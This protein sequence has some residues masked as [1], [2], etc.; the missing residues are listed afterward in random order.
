MAHLASCDW[1]S[2]CFLGVDSRGK[3]QWCF[4]DGL[5]S[6]GV[7]KQLAALVTEVTAAVRSVD[8][9][10]L[11]MREAG[12]LGQYDEMMHARRALHEQRVECLQPF[13]RVQRV[14]FSRGRTTVAGSAPAWSASAAATALRSSHHAV[15]DGFLGATAA[16]ALGAHVRGM[17]TAGELAPGEVAAGLQQATRG[18]LM[19]WLT[20]GGGA[21]AGGSGVAPSLRTLLGALDELVLSLQRCIPELARL[22]LLR[23]EVQATCYPG[24]GAR[25]TRHVDDASR[26]GRVLTCILYLNEAWH[27]GAGGELRLHLSPAATGAA[28]AK[29]VDV[30]PISD[31]L[32]VFWSDARCPHEVLPS[33]EDRYAVSI[34]YTDSRPVSA[35]VA[36]SVAGLGS[37]GFGGAPT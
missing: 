34:W 10:A 1:A 23:H 13:Q 27:A 16:S 35:T 12:L 17:R 5:S 18:D 24:N 14:V 15:I 33:H 26:R 22:S 32:L 11:S 4:E 19:R 37:A 7:P 29:V 9:E 21:G 30:Q 8:E 28:A 36:E 20:P 25:Y 2:G 6:C 3:R 31:R